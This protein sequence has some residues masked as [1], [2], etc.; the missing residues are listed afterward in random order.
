MLARVTRGLGKGVDIL[1][2]SSGTFAGAIIFVAVII[3]TYEIIARYVFKSPTSWSLEIIIFILIWFAF[4]SLAYTQREGRHI[5]IDI[6][7]SRLSPRTRAI[8]DVMSL[9][10]TFLFTVAFIYY[11]YDFFLD[12][13][14]S[15]ETTIGIFV[16]P[17]WVPKLA[18]FAGG[19]I[20]GL[21][22]IKDIV[23]KINLLRTQQLA[24]EKGF[25]DNPKLLIPLFLVSIGIAVWLYLVSPVAGFVMLMLILL[26]GGV[27]I[28]ASLALVGMTGL[29]LLYG[30]L[31]ALPA[32][33]HVAYGSMNNFAWACLPPFILA[34]LMLQSGGAGAELYDLCERWVGHLPGGLAIATIITCAI[35]AAISISSVVVA[36]TIGLIALPALAA[37]GYDKRFSYGVL[38]AG[39]TLGIM[40]PPSGTMLIYSGITEESLGKLFMAGLIP[41]IILVAL[42]SIY[43]SF[44]C[45]RTGAC[46]KIAPYSWKERFRGF[47]TGIWGLLAPIVLI[48]GIYS[49]IFTVLEA[50][51]VVAIYVLVMSL[52][53]RKIKVSQMPAFLRDCA[54]N[55]GM[56]LIIVVGALIMGMLMTLLKLPDT[57]V[58]FVSAANIPAWT[59]IAAL[60]LIYIILG[61]F[62]EVVSAMMITL[63]IVYPLII[64]LGFDGIWFAV[65]LTLTMEMAL[66][67]PPVGLNLFVVQGVSGA[68]LTDV[69][70]GMVPFFIIMLIGL[71]LFALFPQLSIWLPSTMIR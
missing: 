64:S 4:M 66:I 62:L 21:Q 46:Q 8:W 67:T 22:L 56:I 39:G 33:A 38:A 25:K 20:F 18:L 16:A 60:M 24:V 14:K 44:R 63:P 49:G 69:L 43:A 15:R 57:V 59:V 10:L 55:A 37:R 68:P 23:T 27:P 7:T 12:A 48:A 50:G 5:R 70:R 30:G 19:T 3:A 54:S 42:F 53:R 28:F 40:I 13:V 35:F 58:N 61:M 31:N 9:M 29:F 11:S 47:K 17:M 41:G 6:F 71:V 36:I 52:A 45:A 32:I 51:A 1:S 26:F 65:L 34:A 2:L